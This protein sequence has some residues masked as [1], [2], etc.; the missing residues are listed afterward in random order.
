MSFRKLGLILILLLCVNL[1]YAKLEIIV[2]SS[3]DWGPMKTADIEYLCQ[4]VVDHFEKHLRPENQINDAVNVY[5]T[6]V[7]YHFATLDVAD[8]R[9]KY[10]IG[11]QP[12]KADGI[13]YRI[14]DFFYLIQP[15]THEFLHLLQDQSD[16]SKMFVREDKPNLWLM[17][18]I[19][20]MSSIWS[21]REMAEEWKNGSKFG[22][23]LWQADGTGYNFS[24]SFNHFATN[25]LENGTRYQFDGTSAEWLE[26]YEDVMR[27]A[28]LAGKASVQVVPPEQ[29]AFRFLP[30]F[31][32]NPEAWNIIPKMP[33]T[34]GKMLEYMQDWY[35]AVDTQ[36]RQYVEAIAE[37]MDITV[38]SP[39]ISLPEVIAST[40][41][42]ADVNND[43]YVDIRDVLLVRRA[44]QS[45]ILYDTDL[46]NDGVTDELDLLIV[47]AKATEAIVAA[48]PRK[49]KRKVNIMTW[50]A[51]K[52][53]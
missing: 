49:R 51:M 13:G 2:K 24:Q 31:E 34:N 10:K 47:K 4:N 14:L 33:F 11:I 48:A 8:P 29:L 17:E 46:N 20:T 37:I 43:G 36:D 35:D 6:N 40:K 19:A 1:G 28:S 26:K 45:F 32:E 41:I 15:F 30:V 12:I 5:R 18:G 38:T 22:V 27:E 50:G 39:V 7:G 16:S 3:P 53:P 52:K 44:M 25:T 21:L 9:V 23:E 42:D